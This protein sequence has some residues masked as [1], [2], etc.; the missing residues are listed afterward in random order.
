ME[1]SFR[2]ELLHGGTD[3]MDAHRVGFA[4]IMFNC[5]FLIRSRRGIVEAI[6]ALSGC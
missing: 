2:F 5:P 3:A 6:A 4:V 1:R